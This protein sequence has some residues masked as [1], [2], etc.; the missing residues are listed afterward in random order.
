[1]RSLHL[2]LASASVC[3]ALAGCS[4][5]SFED[6][7]DVRGEVTQVKSQVLAQT[8][9]SQARKAIDL[10]TDSDIREITGKTLARRTATSGAFMNAGEFELSGDNGV[11][12]SIVVGVMSPGGRPYFNKCLS[13]AANATVANLGDGAI[14]PETDH[15]I[16]VQGDTLV[17]V[18]Y[19]GISQAQPSVVN[20]LIERIFSRLK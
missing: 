9:T 11:D 5:S 19:I 16:A 18:Q 2:T 6:P 12:A 8:G 7:R 20:R 10:L 3:V 4:G 17:E 1:M 13:R 15:I 14:I